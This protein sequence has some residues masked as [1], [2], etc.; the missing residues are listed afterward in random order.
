MENKNK[1]DFKSIIVIYNILFFCYLTIND[2]QNN[3]EIKKG[4]ILDSEYLNTVFIYY[5]V[6]HSILNYNNQNQIVQYY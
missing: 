4:K 2:L 6:R 1:T 3:I 5:S